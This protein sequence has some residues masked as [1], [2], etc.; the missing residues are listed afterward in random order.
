MTI[1]LLVSKKIFFQ[2]F[3][4]IPYEL[5]F[6]FSLPNFVG[7]FRKITKYETTDDNLNICT[8]NRT[9]QKTDLI[10]QKYDVSEFF[11]ILLSSFIA[12]FS[13][14]D[15]E[16]VVTALCTIIFISINV[17]QPCVL[18]KCKTAQEVC[19]I[20]STI[21]QV[22]EEPYCSILLIC[23]INSVTLNISSNLE[24]KMNFQ[25]RI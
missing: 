20:K 12:S 17:M 16:S 6:E 24:F 4:F 11:M 15:D 21:E 18:N 1:L 19:K 23:L 10:V 25:D 8:N 14:N 7:S 2:T 9:K 5:C 22:L 3:S 13:S